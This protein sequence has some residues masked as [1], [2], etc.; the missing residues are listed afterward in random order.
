MSAHP[1]A[2]DAAPCGY[3][4]TTAEGVVSRVNATLLDWLGTDSDALIG[5]SFS[6]LLRHG[7]R[8]VWLTHHV[9]RLEATGRLDAVS[10]DLV[11]PDGSLLPALVSAVLAPPPPIGRPDVWMTV[12]DASERQAYERDLLVARQAA[13]RAQWRLRALQRVTETCSTAETEE[14]LTA[15]VAEAMARSL[16]TEAVR[17]WLPVGHDLIVAAEYADAPAHHRVAT[18][19][20][21]EVTQAWQSSAPVVP[22]AEDAAFA[23]AAVPLTHADDRL[24][25]LEIVVSAT[26]RGRLADLEVLGVMASVIAQALVRVRLH[27]R[28][29][30]LALHDSLTALPNRVVFVTGV[31]QAV[32]RSGRD[33]R[34]LAL[35][36]IDLDGFKAV[37]D[38]HGHQA[39]DLVLQACA[40]RI[41]DAV[42][43][44]DLV[45]RLGGDE[46][47][48]LCEDCDPTTAVQVAERV[49][50][51]IDRP[52][53]LGVGPVRVGASIGIA[54]G[55]P[56]YAPGAVGALIAAG[57]AQ[58]YAEK[59]RRRDRGALRM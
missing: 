28:M 48:V 20:G 17:V 52:I 29:Q 59:A 8:V 22:E 43:A 12:I 39:G 33:G 58:M 25:V 56:P 35:L 45:A 30:R 11:H 31:E 10:V 36:F 37:N 40:E 24:G 7:A 4:S 54:S 44:G 46:F 50:G 34:P 47:V 16:E 15:G 9:P 13:E 27:A 49:R 57:D 38:A 5:T 41:R 23:C 18:V 55:T 1:S 51:R 26:W 3:V 42:R 19:P 53:E 2:Y 32:A 14:S 21:A 6:Q